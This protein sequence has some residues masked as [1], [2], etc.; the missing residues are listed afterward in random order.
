MKAKAFLIFL[1]A[2]LKACAIC[3]EGSNHR[4]DNHIVIK[5]NAI[6]FY[7]LSNAEYDKLLLKHPD[8]EQGIIECTSDFL[9][10]AHRIAASLNNVGISTRFESIVEVWFE[11]AN[12]TMEKKSFKP[13]ELYGLAM[14]A[15]NKAP[16]IRSDF[17]ANLQP[18]VEVISKYFELNIRF[19]QSI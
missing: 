15:K 4:Q 17:D 2:G 8:W 9:S 7:T 3:S 10:Y 11:Y 16:V 14:F 5:E 6:V 1:L 18:M 19:Q 13:E 12:G